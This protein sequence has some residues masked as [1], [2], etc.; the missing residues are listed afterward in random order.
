[1][2]D[3]R[4]KIWSPKFLLQHAPDFIVQTSNTK[5]KDLESD[6]IKI[7]GFLNEWFPN[8]LHRFNNASSE[9]QTKL[10]NN[11]TGYNVL[12]CNINMLHYLASM[13]NYDCI[14]EA[15]KSDKALYIRD[16]FGKTPLQYALERKN[17]KIV[18]A[19]LEYLS[20][21]PDVSANMLPTELN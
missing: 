16:G 13:N 2:I 10:I 6:D 9:V 20:E 4:A 14:K 7:D 12:P 1:L 3:G 19:L 5:M 11:L 8:M 18:S 15:L 21:N 17:F